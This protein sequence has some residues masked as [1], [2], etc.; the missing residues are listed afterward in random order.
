MT[1]VNKIVPV[2]G[3]AVVVGIVA[4]IVWWQLADPSLWEARDTGIV[5]TEEASRGQFSVVV[6]FT[7]V[8]AIASLLWAVGATVLLRGIGW[9]VVAT[10]VVGAGLASVVAWQ[11]GMTLGPPSPASVSGLSVGDTVPDQL[12]VDG[13]A[14]FIVWP[15]A[16]LVGVL[17]ATWGQGSGDHDDPADDDQADDDQKREIGATTAPVIDTRS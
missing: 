1:G 15:M 6:V 13:I 16:A 10:A 3:S 2:L 17:L 11:L 12:R 9:P 7:L 4:G 5:L 14:P 8:G